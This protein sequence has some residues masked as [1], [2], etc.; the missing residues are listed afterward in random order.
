[1]I[2]EYIYEICTFLNIDVPYVSN[3]TSHF[4]TDTMMAQCNPHMYALFVPEQEE[5]TPDLLF[6]IAH[7]LRHLYQYKTDEEKYFADYKTAEQCTVEEYN[8]QIA[9]VDANAFAAIIMIDIFRLEPQWNG[10][11][12]KAVSTIKKRMNDIVQEIE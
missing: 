7:E 6:S 11:S 1:M 5:V 2:E 3:D 12:K 4:E 9:E 10:L 8:L